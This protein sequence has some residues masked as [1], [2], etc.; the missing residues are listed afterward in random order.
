V[1]A[2]LALLE[3]GDK[4]PFRTVRQQACQVGLSHGQ[5]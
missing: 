2:D 4:N 3:W 5:S 1:R